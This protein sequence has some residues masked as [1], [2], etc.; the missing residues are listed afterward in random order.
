M[1]RIRAGFGVGDLRAEGSH[2]L[3]DRGRGAVGLPR[4]SNR[5]LGRGRRWPGSRRRPGSLSLLPACD[6]VLDGGYLCPIACNGQCSITTNGAE[7]YAY[8][9]ALPGLPVGPSSSWSSPRMAGSDAHGFGACRRSESPSCPC[10]RRASLVRG[11][12]EDRG[13][14][15]PPREERD[16]GARRGRR[17]RRE[18]RA[19]RVQEGGRREEGAQRVQRVQEAGW[20]Q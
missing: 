16:R 20:N 18:Q 19:Q 9:E 10:C 7:T 11:L 5:L 14:R 17:E 2:L 8:R 4:P 12:G 13:G 3:S 1:T 6:L 15:L